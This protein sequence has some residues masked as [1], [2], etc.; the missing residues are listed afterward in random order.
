VINLKSRYTI[1]NTA[2]KLALITTLEEVNKIVVVGAVY[3]ETSWGALSYLTI[4][5]VYLETFYIVKS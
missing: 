5:K 1:S 3:S 4:H 2:L